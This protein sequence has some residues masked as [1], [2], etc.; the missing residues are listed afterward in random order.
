MD[1]GGAN[2]TMMEVARIAA[3]KRHRWK[4][5]LRVVFW[6][7]HSQGRYSSSAWYAD[8]HWEDL[9]RRALVHVNV[10]STGGKGNTEIDT[11]SAAELR[12]LARKSI[13]REVAGPYKLRRVGRAGDKSFWGIGIPAMYGNMSAQPTAP[14]GRQGAHG[15]GYWWHTAHDRLDKMDADILI[16]DSRIYLHTIWRLLTDEVLPLDFAEHARSLRDEL[17]AIRKL[18]GGCF[19]LSLLIDRAST[20]E[21]RCTALEGLRSQPEKLNATLKA[22][23]RVLVPVDYTEGDRFRPDPAL[24]QQTY[25]SLQPLRRLAGLPAGSD[26]A[27]FLEVDMVRARARTGFALAQ[28]IAIADAAL[29]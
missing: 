4:R 28:A 3:H 9:E 16:R 23:C 20:L 22:L 29:A 19:D 11:G 26:A 10:D 13:G 1:N 2:A 7:G 14:G 21:A 18:V 15:T 25:P 12:A 8:A 6:S 27:R 17:E 5:G 24:P